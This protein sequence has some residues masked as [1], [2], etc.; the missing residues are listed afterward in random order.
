VHRLRNSSFTKLQTKCASHSKHHHSHRL[1]DH[2]IRGGLVLTAWTHVAK[3]FLFWQAHCLIL[4]AHPFL[5]GLCKECCIC[6][7]L[8]QVSHSRHSVRSQAPLGTAAAAAWPAGARPLPC[9][10]AGP[11]ACCPQAG[12]CLTAAFPL[13]SPCLSPAWSLG[14][15]YNL[16][17]PHSCPLPA[18][19][20]PSPCL[21]SLL[22]V[23]SFVDSGAFMAPQSCGSVHA[24]AT[25]AARSNS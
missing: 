3:K 23:I 11:G 16:L 19:A 17:G 13:P 7:V 6:L 18:F 2:T 14:L 10:S 1:R 15:M 4:P 25:K 20:S 21:C 22:G 9:P 24:S 12:N 8:L 5:M